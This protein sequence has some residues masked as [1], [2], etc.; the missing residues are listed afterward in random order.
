MWPYLDVEVFPLAAHPNDP[1]GGAMSEP[2]DDGLTIPPDYVANLF[3]I[4]GRVAVITGGGSGLGARS[5]SAMPRP[6]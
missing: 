3:D 6:A 1:G 5:R 4:A 2:T